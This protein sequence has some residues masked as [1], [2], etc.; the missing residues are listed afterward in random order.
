[1]SLGARSLG[2]RGVGLVEIMLALTIL[3]VVMMALGGLMFQ[4]ARDT[5]LSAQV[6]YRSA[7]LQNGA[8]WAQTIPWDSIPSLTGWGTTD[9]IGQLVYQRYMEYGISG[10]A[11]NLTVII[12]PVTTVGSSAR[13]RPD[14]VSVTRA[15]PLTT[16]PLKVR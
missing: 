1:M 12:R 6:A 8:A 4:V 10:N 14:T 16:A 13:V 5:R 15:R 3:S 9:T 2:E 7:A 11:R